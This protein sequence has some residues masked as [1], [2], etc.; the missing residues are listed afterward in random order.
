MTYRV[1]E[2]TLLAYPQHPLCEKGCDRLPNDPSHRIDNQKLGSG[3][4]EQ[5]SLSAWN[6]LDK[7]KL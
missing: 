2:V 3:A 7:L 1:R 6:E 4:E 5:E